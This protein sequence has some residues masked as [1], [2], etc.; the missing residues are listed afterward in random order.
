MF[1][2]F[3]IL[4]I[5]PFYFPNGQSAPKNKYYIPIFLEGDEIIFVFLPTSKIKIEPS[6]IK[7]GCHDVSKGSYTCYIFQEKVE[8]TDCGFYFD[9][10]TCVYSYQINAFSKPMIEDVYKVED[11]DFE[12][13]GELKKTEKIA[14]IQ[15]LLNSKFIKLKVKRA[16]SKYL[17]DIS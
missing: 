17:T 12:I 5:T 6:K 1:D 9:F 4:Y 10:D 2:L 16:L 15:C 13:I 8:I 7:H 11:V 3:H 14:L